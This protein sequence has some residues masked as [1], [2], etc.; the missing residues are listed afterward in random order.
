MNV[1]SFITQKRRDVL[2]SV[3]KLSNE[4][5]LISYRLLKHVP[6]KFTMWVGFDTARSFLRILTTKS[7]GRMFQVNKTGTGKINSLEDY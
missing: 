4:Y 1:P 7:K 5:V 3:Q 6:Y 2:I